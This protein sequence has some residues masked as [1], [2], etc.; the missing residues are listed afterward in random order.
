MN[1]TTQKQSFFT[2]QNMVLI[3]LFAAVMAV[4]SQLS[5]PMPSGVPITIQLFG[6]A[7]LGSVLGWKRGFLSVLIYI[8]LGAIG[9]PIFSNL[10]GGISVLIG[11]T[12]G[13]ILAW[14]IMAIL[15]GIYPKTSNKTA[16]FLIRIVLGLVGMMVVE[17]IGGLQWS[18]LADGKTLGAIMVY[19]FTAFIPKDAIITVIGIIVGDQMRR[20]LL[21]NNF[22]K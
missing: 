14:P 16:A 8:L 7:L 5:I 22:I 1:T 4:I 18:I 11:P 17:F 2:T 6:I 13:Y 9:L 10:R 21:K 19:S 12:G 3:A 15:C 20:L